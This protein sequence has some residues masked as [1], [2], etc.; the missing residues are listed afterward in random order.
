MQEKKK[1]K[2]S[3]RRRHHHHHHSDGCLCAPQYK[4]SNLL[5][6]CLFTFIPRKN[7]LLYQ[8]FCESLPVGK[9]VSETLAP[10]ESKNCETTKHPD[11][12][13]TF[14][15]G[16][17]LHQGAPAANRTQPG[18]SP[19]LSNTPCESPGCDLFCPRCRL[20]FLEP[21]DGERSDDGHF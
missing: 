6:C 4:V 20:T 7:T 8:R 16:E 11:Y 9:N 1:K 3:K 15:G 13:V 12:G 10:S 19:G 14:S 21:T 2:T 18:P 5:I 17:I